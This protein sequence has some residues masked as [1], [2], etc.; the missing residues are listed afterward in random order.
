MNTSLNPDQ[1]YQLLAARD[2]RSD[3][4]FYV[5]VSTTGIYCRPVCRVKLPRRERCSFYPS[6]AAAEQAGYRPCLRC[7]PELAPGRSR[8]DA[9][10]QLAY[11]ANH[12]IRAGALSQQSLEAFAASLHISSRQLRRATEQ[13]FGASP[14]ALAQTYRLLSAKQLLTDT[15]L[16]A[17]DIAFASGF[18][19]VRRF[20]DAF[21]K[22]YRL[23]PGA[24]RKRH[25]AEN[26]NAAF[27]IRL[28][29][30]PPLAWNV[31]IHFLHSRS[32]TG[33]SLI[34]GETLLKTLRVGEYQG[35]F[36]AR[37][38]SPKHQLIVEASRDLAPVFVPLVNLLRQYFDLDASPH[39]IDAHLSQ[40]SLLSRCVQSLPGLRLPG[41][42]DAFELCARAI[43][44]Q[45]VSVK[46]AS[47]VFNR[48]CQRFGAPLQTPFAEL[49]RL[50]PLADTVAEGPLDE[51]IALGLNERRA[52]TLLNIARAFSE[53]R[54]HFGYGDTSEEIC[55]DLQSLPGIGPWTAQYIALRALGD[56]NAFPASDLALM[57]A[58]Q[59]KTARQ[60][61]QAVEGLQPW[62]AYAAIH[63][64]LSL[65]AGG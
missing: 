21:K 51:L 23:T 34:Q 49:N 6:A 45:Q 32:A 29:Y 40:H 5:G 47:T 31:L 4:D 64:W 44:G 20:N 61:E 37:Q 38:D 16:R 9:V 13:T 2:A 39:I 52:S 15:N 62:R 10:A 56:P 18:S 19:S 11:L 48:F 46:A 12:K 33:T 36:S 60:A 55:R 53:G 59:V 41:S 63:L 3:G 14:S 24:L 50:P 26:G 57:Q 65:S 27:V 8:Q 22:H 17:T 54:L 7:R 58:L 30:R 35:W 43:I 25:T 28:S 1:C 42:L